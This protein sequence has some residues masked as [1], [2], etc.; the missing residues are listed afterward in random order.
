MKKQ[1]VKFPLLPLAAVALLGAVPMLGGCDNEPDDLGDVADEAGDALEDA[2][3]AVDDT[4][5]EVDD[6]TDGG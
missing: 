4:L 3:D 6:A 2:G 1:T 5:D